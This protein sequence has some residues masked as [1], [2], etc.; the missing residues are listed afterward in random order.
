MIAEGPS[1]KRPPH[2]ALDPFLSFRPLKP[3]FLAMALSAALLTAACDRQA[4]GTAQPRGESAPSAPQA[5]PT[6]TIDRSKAGSPL[7]ELTVIDA[8]GAKLDLA[9]LRGRPVLINLWATWCAPCVA[10][11]PTLDALAA[12]GGGLAVLAISQDMQPAKVGAFL[13]ERGIARLH[14]WLDEKAD[15]S[16]KL[17][18]ATL[19][20]TILYDARGKE[21]WRFAG[22]NDWAGPEA[23]AL[24]AEAASR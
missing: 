10:E 23:Q 4:D 18:A 12:K 11:L 24:I 21:V 1:A 17:G 20:T 6:G 8:A 22:G 19:P 14:P 2:I 15:L 7:P 5:E 3:V 13:K 9:S 16:F